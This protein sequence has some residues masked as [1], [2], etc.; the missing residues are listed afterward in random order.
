MVDL[1]NLKM[2]SLYGQPIGQDIDEEYNIK[3]EN[4]LIKR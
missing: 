1:L 4:W 2:S 3:P